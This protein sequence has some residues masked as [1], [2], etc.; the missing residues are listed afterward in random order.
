M[1]N[2][3]DIDKTFNEASKSLDEAET[4]PGFDK[5]WGRIEEKLDKK[6]E[7]KKIIKNWF[8]YGIAASL[9]IC[10]GIF[11]F[12]N[13]KESAPEILQNVIAENLEIQKLN[14]AAEIDSIVKTNI[15]KESAKS[16]LSKNNQVLAY[17]DV[18]KQKNEI[19]LSKNQHHINSEQILK[20]V[21]EKVFPKTKDT[22]KVKNI[23]EV[24]AMGIK[25]EKSSVNAS[26]RIISSNDISKKN[27]IIETDTAESL[28]PLNRF[29]IVNE[30]KEPLVAGMN[31]NFKKNRT[32]ES[33]P[34]LAENMKDKSITNSLQG[35]V[36]GLT[37]SPYGSKGSGKVDIV[38]RGSSSINSN[39]PLYVIDGKISDAEGFK[40]INPDIIESVTVLKGEK[41]VTLYGNKASN[42]VVV[43]ETK[44][45][46]TLKKVKDSVK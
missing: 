34:K 6:E 8:P 33:S 1:E 14:K 5:V 13:K 32:F 39:P 46:E 28:F 15:K 12:L 4:F 31:R 30:M 29:D 42:G 2:N 23:E 43:I 20:E 25:R 17:Q 35:S 37:I 21:E 40:Q 11:Y 16:I 26:T 3:H 10:T 9:L 22:L 38:I 41:A 45:T 36:S 27:N 44:G 18:K 19:N 24:I 7:K